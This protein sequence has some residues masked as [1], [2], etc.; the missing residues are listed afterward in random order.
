M[1]EKELTGYPS[2]DKPWLK[3]YSEEALRAKVPECS[4]YDLLY[5]NNCANTDDIAL[6]YM[7][8]KVTYGGLFGKIEEVAKAFWTWGIRKGDIVAICAVNIPEIIY[9]IYALNRIGAII[10]LIDPRSN[11]LRF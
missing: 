1:K 10:N 5:G 8:S 6:E 2:I 11:I 9:S 3:Y 4:M 7:G